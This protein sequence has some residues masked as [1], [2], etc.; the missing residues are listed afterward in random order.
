[1]DSYDGVIGILKKAHENK[2]LLLRNHSTGNISFPAGGREE[3]E[4]VSLLIGNCR[5]KTSTNRS[6]C[7]NLGMVYREGS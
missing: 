4:T 7:R 5:E 6:R 3:G 1:M 2:Y